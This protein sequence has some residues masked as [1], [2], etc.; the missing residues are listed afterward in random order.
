[1]SVEPDVDSA[2][3]NTPALRDRSTE[4]M[5]KHG[6]TFPHYMLPVRQSDLQKKNGPQ[7]QLQV[8]SCRQNPRATRS[9]PD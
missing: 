4:E 7:V 1:M 9:Y 8:H 3:I 6:L 5:L 2:K